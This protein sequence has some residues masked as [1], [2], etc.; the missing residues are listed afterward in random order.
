MAKKNEA[1]QEEVKQETEL[2]E[3]EAQDTEAQASTEKQEKEQ[4]AP[5]EEVKAKTYKF[6]SSNKYLTVA[7]LGIQFRDGKAETTNLEVA[8]ALAKVGGVEMVEE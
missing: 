6:T 5:Q 3:T 8:K 4:E 7:N 1:P 2:Q